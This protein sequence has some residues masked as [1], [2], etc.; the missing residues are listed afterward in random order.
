MITLDVKNAFN[1]TLWSKIV[2]TMIAWDVS[3]HIINI[4]EDYFIT[5]AW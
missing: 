5:V 2:D 3:A 4:V 1:S